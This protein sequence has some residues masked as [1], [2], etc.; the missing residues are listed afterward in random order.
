MFRQEG[1]HVDLAEL[2]SVQPWLPLTGVGV[3]TPTQQIEQAWAHLWTQPWHCRICFLLVGTD[4]TL[5]PTDGNDGDS[6]SSQPGQAQQKQSNEQSLSNAYSCATHATCTQRGRGA[7]GGGGT[8]GA[9]AGHMH[10]GQLH[11][12]G[13]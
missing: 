2:G 11:K 6:Q 1:G 9:E 10:F 8:E 13:R 12:G 5:V 3:T 4:C 7:E